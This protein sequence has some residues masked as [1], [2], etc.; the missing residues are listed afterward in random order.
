MVDTPYEPCG[1][2]ELTDEG[3]LR[4]HVVAGS[5][6]DGVWVNRYGI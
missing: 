5:P 2:Q 4:S 1:P 6:A 3:G